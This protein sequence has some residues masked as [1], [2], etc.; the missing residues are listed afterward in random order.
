MKVRSFS[1]AVRLAGLVA[2]ACLCACHPADNIADQESVRQSFEDF[3]AA[4]AARHAQQAIDAL[5]QST[6]DYL[7]T[8]VTGPL[9]P[10]AA[11]E[12]VRELVH[13][14][15]AK[16]TPGGIRPGFRLETPLQRVLD[17]GW[18]NEND[19]G[20]LDLGPV[21]VQGGQARAE[22]MWQGQPTTLQ[23]VFV[24]ESGKWTIDLLQLVSYAELALRMDRTV[25]GQAETEQIARLVA[26]VPTL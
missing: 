11:D 16:L 10:S 1:F 12:E 2:A 24:R 4:L 5:D 3:K 13:Q 9:D 17:A 22:I 20:E 7:R 18:I 26:Q 6:R 23:L 15:V 8:S 21:I 25:K 14:T 19:L